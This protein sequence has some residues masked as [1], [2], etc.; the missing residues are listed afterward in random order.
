MQTL[1]TSERYSTVPETISARIRLILLVGICFPCARRNSNPSYREA[2]RAAASTREG[3]LAMAALCPSP[4]PTG[5]T[6][7]AVADAPRRQ[8]TESTA[9]AATPET[10]THGVTSSPRTGNRGN[11]S[12]Q[13]SPSS[14]SLGE[15]IPPAPQAF[16]RGGTTGTKLPKRKRGEHSFVASAAGPGSFLW[17]VPPRALWASPLARR[18]QPLV[19]RRAEASTQR[20]AATSATGLYGLFLCFCFL[21]EVSA[22]PLLLLP[23]VG[24]PFCSRVL[25]KPCCRIGRRRTEA[26]QLTCPLTNSPPKSSPP[27]S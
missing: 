2:W 20:R 24:L 14:S 11:G 4:S 6:A 26:R 12:P 27:P 5:G 16:W 8:H 3:T 1:N 13:T 25:A 19:P 10:P 15:A 22:D 23:G 17:A 7:T 18:R 9:T 21:G